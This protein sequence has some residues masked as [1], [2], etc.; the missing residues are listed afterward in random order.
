MAER[1]IRNA[2][3]QGSIPCSG[4]YRVQRLPEAIGP[5]TLPAMTPPSVRVV[6]HESHLGRWETVFRAP[7][8]PLRPYIRGYKGYV[9]VGARPNRRRAVATTDVALIVNFGSPL[10][11]TDPVDPGAGVDYRSAFVAGPCDRYS[12][13][14]WTGETDGVQVDL[15]AIGARLIL[16]LPM[17]ELTNRAIEFEDVGGAWARG[18][19]E[20][21]HDEPSWEARFALLD[22][23]VISRL[24]GASEPA[25]AVVRAWQRLEASGGRVPI[26]A[27]ADEVGYSHEH[28]TR[29]FRQQVGLPPK[30][31]A[32]LLRFDRLMRRLEGRNVATWADLASQCGY[33][34]QAHLI[35]DFR[36]FAGTPPGEF[37]G[38]RLPE[39][40]GVLG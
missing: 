35:R 28:L 23:V 22:S 1:R 24:A 19:A 13:Y 21:L 4:S 31:F 30:T 15:T 36:R 5:A 10:G 33:Y 3:V 2:Q 12:L 40:G 27:L 38:L 6:R 18:L 20:R 34:D 16:G 8:L 37:M 7:A 25:P 26:R 17:D 9:C 32:Q 11:L 29:R 39:G 14:E